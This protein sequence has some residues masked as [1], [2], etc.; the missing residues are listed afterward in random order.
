MHKQGHS[1]G[2]GEPVWV[3]SLQLVHG[4]VSM[5]NFSCVKP[6]IREDVDTDD[7]LT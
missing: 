3:V 4:R 2:Q 1:G 6:E 5:S 7:D